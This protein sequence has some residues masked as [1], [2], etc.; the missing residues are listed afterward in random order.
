[1]KNNGQNIEHISIPGCEVRGPKEKIKVI[2]WS[3]KLSDGALNVKTKG[4]TNKLMN[5]LNVLAQIDYPCV[6][7][8]IEICMQIRWLHKDINSE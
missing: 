4:R 2:F 7:T 8:L 3:M 6:M 5:E 1:M